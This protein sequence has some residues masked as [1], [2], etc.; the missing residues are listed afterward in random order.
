[1]CLIC[2]RFTFEDPR[3]KSSPTGSSEA[4]ILWLLTCRVEAETESPEMLNPADL[5]CIKEEAD[6]HA[7]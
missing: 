2:G 7:R 4:H 1:M 6:G 5:I 3:T